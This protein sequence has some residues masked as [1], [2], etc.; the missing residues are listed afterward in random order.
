M[1]D[2]SELVFDKVVLAL[3]N[4]PPLNPQTRHKSFLMDKRYIQ[5][6]WNPAIFDSVSPENSI[7]FIGTGQTT[8]DLA[9]GLY[10]R[11]HKGKRI[12]KS[13]RGFFP[14]VQKKVEP[15]PSFFDELNELSDIPSIFR[16]VRK[17]FQIANEKGLDSRAV[18]DSLR[19]NTR[20]IWMNLSIAEKKRFLRHVFRYWGIIRNRIPH[21]SYEIISKLTS[22]GRLKVIQGRIIDIIPAENKMEAEY[23]KKGT[24][25]EETISADIIIVLVL[26]RITRRLINH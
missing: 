4:A 25:G 23:I 16:I 24:T 3:G 19:P 22:S 13:R 11:N 14:L 26:V 8:V 9:T 12:S 20:M 10:K 5:N 21:A 7:L 17:H 18:I 2:G 15:Y 1:Q 6:P